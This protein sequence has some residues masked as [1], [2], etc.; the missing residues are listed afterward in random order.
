MIKHIVQAVALFS[1]FTLSTPTEAQDAGV[2]RDTEVSI[3]SGSGAGTTRKLV[4]W[5]DAWANI[6]GVGYPQGQDGF[7]SPVGIGIA[8]DGTLWQLLFDQYQ[9]NTQWYPWCSTQVAVQTVYWWVSYSTVTVPGGRKILQFQWLNTQ[10]VTGRALMDDN[11]LWQLVA[12][13][14]TCNCWNACDVSDPLTDAKYMW[15]PAAPALPSI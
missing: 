5:V 15:I 13:D 1:L 14:P 3:D 2:M 10:V 9:N 4:A 7:F 12:S 6:M 8:D 11:T